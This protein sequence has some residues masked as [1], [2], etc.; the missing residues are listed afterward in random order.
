ML[1]IPTSDGTLPIDKVYLNNSATK[2]RLRGDHP[3]LHVLCLGAY[4]SPPLTRGPRC[5][6]RSILDGVRITPAY[7]GTTRPRY[8]MRWMPWDHPRLRGDHLVRFIWLTI[9]GGSPPL[10]RGPPS[11]PAT[12]CRATRITP[13]YAGTTQSLPRETRTAP[14]HPRLRGD[15]HYQKHKFQG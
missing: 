8:S 3:L 7:A 10:T 12:A 2:P 15:H 4:G 1:I 13:A 5:L 6:E 11:M 9:S 14:D